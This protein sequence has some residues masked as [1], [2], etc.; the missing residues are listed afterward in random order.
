M[1]Y[2]MRETLICA[3]A[4]TEIVIKCIREFSLQGK[5][6]VIAPSSVYTELAVFKNDENVKIVRLSTDKFDNHVISEISM[7]RDD[8]YDDAVIVSG[9]LGFTGF[10]N[11]I[12]MID[13]LQIKNL[14]FYNKIGHTE[15][16]K[17]SNGFTRILEKSIIGFLLGILKR[18]RPIEL[19]IER[20]YIRCA[21]LLG[22]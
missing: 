4:R 20:I 15:I 14:I 1:K 2:E 8:L 10:H 3:S 18:I 12:E 17:V 7:L 9:G 22:L 13:R 19:L 21:E 5:V 11:V 16:V 6:T